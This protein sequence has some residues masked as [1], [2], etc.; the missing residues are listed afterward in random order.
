MLKYNMYFYFSEDT[1]NNDKFARWVI[2]S[3]FCATSA[4]VMFI[5]SFVLEKVLFF[6]SLFAGVALMLFFIVALRNAIK[7]KQ[8]VYLANCNGRWFVSNYSH[9]KKKQMAKYIYAYLQMNGYITE[10]PKSLPKDIIAGI[11]AQANAMK[12]QINEYDFSLMVNEIGTAVISSSGDGYTLTY[13]PQHAG[14]LSTVT[15]SV[16]VTQLYKYNG[17]ILECW[18]ED[19]DE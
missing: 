12:N 6:A 18:I 9:P 11:K 10:L 15:E 7:N 5:I 1:R 16:D 3:V 8:S 2:A 17:H 14:R 19:I 13:T 4:F